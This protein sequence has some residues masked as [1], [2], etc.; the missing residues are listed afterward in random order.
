MID[1]AEIQQRVAQGRMA[2]LAS[3]VPEGLSEARSVLAEALDA[4][5]AECGVPS[6]RVVLGGFSQGSML[7]CDF[8]LNDERPLAG[9]VLFSSTLL[10]RDDWQRLAP[11][12][13]GLPVLQSHGRAD[14]VLPFAL[15]EQQRDLL[16][17]AGLDV[18]FIAFNGG[19][20]IAPSGTEALSRFV[21]Q[22]LG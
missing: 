12:R 10:C 7:S 18:E 15:A 8:A 22:H 16:L 14:P 21:N 20:G 1:I 9:L 19:H 2:E 6:S 11:K 17:E 4:L 3:R 13:K 5:E